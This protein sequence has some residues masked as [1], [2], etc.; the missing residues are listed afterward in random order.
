GDEST[1]RLCEARLVGRRGLRVGLGRFLFL[2][3]VL[4]CCFVLARL[5]GFLGSSLGTFLGGLLAAAAALLRL[6]L[7]D[8]QSLADTGSGGGAALG[9]RAA[10]RDHDQRDHDDLDRE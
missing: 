2:F 4:F 3:L 5:G 1:A 8:A 9:A 6:F 7:F 10:Q